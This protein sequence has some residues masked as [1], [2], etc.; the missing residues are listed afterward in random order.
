M[1]VH[2][3]VNELFVLG[4]PDHAGDELTREQTVA[5][6]TGDEVDPVVCEDDVT[7]KETGSS[8]PACLAAEKSSTVF[9]VVA[10]E[11]VV[12]KAGPILLGDPQLERPVYHKDLIQSR[13]FSIFCRGV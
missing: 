9:V 3:E 7:N 13:T 1:V 4:T 5:P 10:R 6:G 11:E 2:R 8:A 12:V